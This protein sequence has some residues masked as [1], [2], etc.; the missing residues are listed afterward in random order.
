MTLVFFLFFF[1]FSFIRQKG[2]FAAYSCEEAKGG[3]G[4]LQGMVK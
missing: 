4:S 2:G 1:I 3:G